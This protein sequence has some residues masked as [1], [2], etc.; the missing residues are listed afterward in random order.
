MSTI[1]QKC[2]ISPVTAPKACLLGDCAGDSSN[3]Q[4][5]QPALPE[6]VMMAWH[7]AHSIVEALLTQRYCMLQS[8]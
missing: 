2:L 1:F 3:F 5:H 6:N 8:G 4:H 7:Q